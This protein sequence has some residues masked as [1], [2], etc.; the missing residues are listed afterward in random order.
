MQVIYGVELRPVD[1]MYE[2]YD[3]LWYYEK[4]SERGTCT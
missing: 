2:L 3:R 4:C 1:L